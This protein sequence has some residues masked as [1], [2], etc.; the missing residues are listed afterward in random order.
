MTPNFL[1][2]RKGTGAVSSSSSSASLYALP[3]RRGL[4]SAA[5]A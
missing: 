4:D 5:A 2:F 3:P 1:L